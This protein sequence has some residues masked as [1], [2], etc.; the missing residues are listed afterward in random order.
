MGIGAQ[1]LSPHWNQFDPCALEGTEPSAR[2]Y[3]EPGTMWTT[4]FTVSFWSSP[5]P[6]PC[7][8]VLNLSRGAHWRHPMML[9]S[10]RSR[11]EAV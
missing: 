11:L 3:A 7:G 6:W 4:L 2:F 1:S 10:A 5:P 8:V 9:R